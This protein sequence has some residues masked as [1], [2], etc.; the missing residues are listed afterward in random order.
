M[1]VVTSPLA[2]LGRLHFAALRRALAARAWWRGWGGEPFDCFALTP[3]GL[4]RLG[5]P[6]YPPGRQ[7]AGV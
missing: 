6:R 3:A 1:Y 2:G 5:S 4:R 7:A